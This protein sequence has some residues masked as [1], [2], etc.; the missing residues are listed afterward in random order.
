MKT[1]PFLVS[2][3]DLDGQRF[4][5]CAL[6]RDINALDG[7]FTLFS[8]VNYEDL[9]GGIKIDNSDIV[10]GFF[11][12]PDSYD[13]DGWQCIEGSVDQSLLY[14]PRLD[15]M[16]KDRFVGTRVIG[17]RLAERFLS[18]CQ[19]KV[20]WNEMFDTEYY[21]GLLYPDRRADKNIKRVYKD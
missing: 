19:G 12:T 7:V 17:S 9:K 15:Q 2:I 16:R 21:E 4:V 18:A 13:N 20:A 3:P 10:A 5:C 14:Q 6:Y 11:V 1:L 8:L